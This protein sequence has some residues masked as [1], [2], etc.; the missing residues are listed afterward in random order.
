MRFPLVVSLFVCV[1]AV[2]ATPLLAQSPNGNINGLIS[3]PSS[4]A[5]VGA[6]PQKL[7]T[8]CREV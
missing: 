5:G 1:L 3:D 2:I 7:P 8:G 6:A 4:A